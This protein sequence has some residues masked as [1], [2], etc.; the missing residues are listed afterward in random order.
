MAES[1]R[2]AARP[3]LRDAARKVADRRPGGTMPFHGAEH[4]MR[5]Q[6]STW[7]LAALVVL[8]LAL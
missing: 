3:A 2:P 7:I 6:L 5:S 1:P 8:A 4:P